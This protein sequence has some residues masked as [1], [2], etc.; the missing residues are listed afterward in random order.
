ML[1]SRIRRTARKIALV[2]GAMLLLTIATAAISLVARRSAAPP[3]LAGTTGCYAVAMQ[4]GTYPNGVPATE[5]G[6][7]APV[8]SALD[9]L[10]YSLDDA[11]TYSGGRDIGCVLLHGVPAYAAPIV[12]Y[13]PADTSATSPTYSY[14]KSAGCGNQ[15]ATTGRYPASLQ[16]PTVVVT[17]QPTSA[18][19]GTT[20]CTLTFST[21]PASSKPPAIGSGLV[22]VVV[23]S[24]TPAPGGYFFWVC[25]AQW[26]SGGWI[27]GVQCYWVT[28]AD[29]GGQDILNSAD[30]TTMQNLASNTLSGF[31]QSLAPQN[32]SPCPGGTTPVE[33]PLPAGIPSPSP[34]WLASQAQAQA[35]AAA[36]ALQGQVG[37]TGITGS[38]MVYCQ[39]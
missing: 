4:S 37:N 27:N 6:M 32:P 35:A 23:V 34:A 30:T 22:P 31:S 39:P 26:N 2:I 18:A 20:T 11:G 9:A 24:P 16:G 3:V 8:K 19:A 7:P 15:V 38:E 14:R 29:S 12:A 5:A 36:Y 28:T 33:P 1:I 10:G 17:E 13:E 25:A 21:V